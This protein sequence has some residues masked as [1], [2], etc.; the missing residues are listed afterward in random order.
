MYNWVS[1]DG[2]FADTDGKLDWVVPDA[3]Q[4]KIA[5]DGM[6]RYDTVLFGRRTYQV[7]EE[8]WKRALEQASNLTVPDPHDRGRPS[9]EHYRIAVALNA[10]AKVVFSTRLTSPTWKNTRILAELD[11]AAVDAMKREPGRDMII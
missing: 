3:Q 1:A 10:M 6:E 8:V 7:F 11:P 4:T 5:A 2:F 9:H